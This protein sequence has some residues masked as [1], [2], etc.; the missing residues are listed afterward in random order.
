MI[1]H[2]G[3]APVGDGQQPFRRLD[4]LG[5]S[6]APRD[7]RRRRVEDRLEGFLNLVQRAQARFWA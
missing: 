3:T 4:G 2:E 1:G 5:R 7:R 6:G